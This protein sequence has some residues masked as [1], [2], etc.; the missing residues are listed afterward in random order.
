LDI[1]GGGGGDGGGG[2]GGG[3]EFPI[4]G[5]QSAAPKGGAAAATASSAADPKQPKHKTTEAGDASAPF[6]VGSYVS[7]AF[8]LARPRRSGERR[9]RLS[10]R[11]CEL[12]R[13]KRYLCGEAG[14]ANQGAWD[15]FRDV[16]AELTTKELHGE[17][18]GSQW[19]GAAVS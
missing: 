18:G 8:F 15:H 4:V 7:V 9:G 14:R 5:E 16:T 6:P 2:G 12:Q 17:L 11:R 19:Q 13:N 10:R 1:I 3:V